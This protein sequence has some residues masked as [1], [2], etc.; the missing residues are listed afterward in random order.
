MF[1]QPG[2]HR[3]VLWRGARHV[4]RDEAPERLR[5][6]GVGDTGQVEQEGDGEHPL[7]GES[8]VHHQEGQQQDEEAAPRGDERQPLARLFEESGDA[9]SSAFARLDAG[10]PDDQQRRDGDEVGGNVGDEE[11]AESCSHDDGRRQGGS[12][13]AADTSGELHHSRRPGVVLLRDQH[14]DRRRVGRE[15]EGC[16]QAAERHRDV[17][18]PDLDG[19]RDDEQHRG[20]RADRGAGVGYEQR[21]AAVPAIDQGAD[22]WRHQQHGDPGGH[23]DQRQLR[24]R[25]GFLIH[26]D[27]EPETR[28]GRPQQGNELAEP[29]DRE[30]L[31]SFGLEE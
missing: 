24:G 2:Q 25:P 28:H 23:D 19:P 6:L 1:H 18:V 10:E 3:L 14:R 7:E 22:E 21:R 17:E 30:G 9:A 20:E 4:V 12:E 11:R 31:D 13:D 16:E 27:G 26:P 5:L 15:L 29:D 8:E